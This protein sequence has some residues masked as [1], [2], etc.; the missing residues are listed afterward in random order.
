MDQDTLTTRDSSYWDAI[1]SKNWLKIYQKRMLLSTTETSSI[2]IIIILIKAPSHI[3]HV[4]NKNNGT[5]KEILLLSF[6]PSTSVQRK[7]R[8]N[9]FLN[10]MNLVYEKCRYSELN[11]FTYLL[12]Q[13]ITHY[14]QVTSD[15]SKRH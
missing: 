7:V 11:T 10:N 9:L 14:Y 1:R 3:N 8:L 12:S 2:N 5:H 6:M 15:I 13:P 4:D